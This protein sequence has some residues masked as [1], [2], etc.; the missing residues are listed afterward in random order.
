MDWK[1]EKAKEGER[2][3][4]PVPVDL[5]EPEPDHVEGEA[6]SDRE[7]D[8]GPAQVRR[9]EAVAVLENTFIKF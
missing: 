4:D 2:D 6:G 3:T 8:D 7:L 1:R 9:E 5:L